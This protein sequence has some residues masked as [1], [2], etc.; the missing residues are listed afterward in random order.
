MDDMHEPQPVD[1]GSEPSV[2]GHSQ[3]TDIA[4]PD[5]T[6]EDVE[7]AA[8][9][10]LDHGAVDES[11]GEPAQEPDLLVELATAMHTAAARER[12]RIETAIAERLGERVEDLQARA[13]SESDELRDLANADLDRIEEWAAGEIDRIRRE[14]NRR[15]EGRRAA[16]DDSLSEH[17]ITVESEIARVARATSIYREQLDAFFAELDTT[18]D[19]AEIARLAGSVPPMPDLEDLTTEPPSTAV[20]E[21][22]MPIAEPEATRAEADTPMGAKDQVETETEAEIGVTGEAEPTVAESEPEM[23]RPLVGVLAPAAPAPIAPHTA[24]VSG[25]P[26]P[27]LDVVAEDRST[28]TEQPRHRG[29]MDL[30]RTIAPWSRHEERDTSA[31]SADA[32]AQANGSSRRTAT[33][34]QAGGS[35]SPSCGNGAVH[36]RQFGTRDSL[37]SPGRSGGR[38]DAADLKSAARKGVRV[39]IPASAPA[40]TKGPGPGSNW[41]CPFSSRRSHLGRGSRHARGDSTASWN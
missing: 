13:T 14:A 3:T 22:E 1:D 39:R 19:P 34:G 24:I 17:A 21:S 30:L 4:A 38:A 37:R 15:S 20:A 35:P 25:P 10:A 11:A 5:G 28:S 9:D 31:A 27:S 40:S 41:R 8:A 16:L 36:R 26:A 2:E 12:E 23:E 7:P 18:T 32:S 6:V 33:V 29:P